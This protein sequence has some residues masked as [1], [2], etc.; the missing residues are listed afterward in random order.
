[1]KIRRDVVVAAALAIAT[2]SWL[3]AVEGKQGI[4]RD[5]GQYFRAG[6]HYWSWFESGWQN[7]RQGHLLR[8]FTRSGIDAFW[9][10]NPE[11]PPVMKTLSGVSWRLFHRCEC[12][13]PKRGLHPPGTALAA[14]FIF[15]IPVSAV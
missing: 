10:D 13:G 12:M 8:T 15:G 2:V 3:L 6:E 5:E 7:L 1:M 11:H 4:G 9:G 14:W